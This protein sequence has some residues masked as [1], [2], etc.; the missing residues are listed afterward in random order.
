MVQGID[1]RVHDKARGGRA[2]FPTS[3]RDAALADTVQLGAQPFLV[4]CGAPDARKLELSGELATSVDGECVP[5]VMR[6]LQL[7]DA[8]VGGVGGQAAQH[9]EGGVH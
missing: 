4:Q 3:R 8:Q 2:C 5:T 7:A 6:L 9:G 1:T